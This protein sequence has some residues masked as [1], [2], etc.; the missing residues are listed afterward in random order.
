MVCLSITTFVVPYLVFSL[1]FVILDFVIWLKGAVV[2]LCT[3]Q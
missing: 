2:P 1:N 3:G